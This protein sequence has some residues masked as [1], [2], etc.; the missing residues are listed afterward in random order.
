M[1]LSRARTGQIA[2]SVDVH[3]FMLNF[4]DPDRERNLSF[5]RK[6]APECE[7]DADKLADNDPACEFVNN[8]AFVG[9]VLKTNPRSFEWA[10]PDEDDE[11]DN[12]TASL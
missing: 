12:S 6:P 3:N 7:T 10:D 9:S 5:S 4:T 11:A 8:I 2:R 1:L